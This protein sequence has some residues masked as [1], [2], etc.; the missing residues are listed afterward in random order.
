[1]NGMNNTDMAA[2]PI[3]VEFTLHD[4]ANPNVYSYEIVRCDR[5]SNDVRIVSQGVLSRPVIKKFL[6]KKVNKPQAYTP[7]GII[8]TNKLNIEPNVLNGGEDPGYRVDNLDNHNLYQYISPDVSY[9]RESSKLIIDKTNLHIN[10]VKYIFG[11]SAD[12]ASFNIISDSDR[13]D[14]NLYLS[15][16]T[17]F[18]GGIT[19]VKDGKGFVISNKISK[20]SYNSG[21]ISSMAFL[22]YDDPN[23]APTADYRANSYICNSISII[24]AI[25][26]TLGSNDDLSINVASGHLNDDGNFKVPNISGNVVNTESPVEAMKYNFNYF[27]L[28]CQS[29]YILVN[30]HDRNN[31][32]KAYEDGH[33]Y[34][35]IKRSVYNQ[36][37][38]TNYKFADSLK[39]DSLAT[40]KDGK[41]SE[42][43]SDKITNIDKYNFCNMVCWYGYNELFVAEN[44]DNIYFK[45]WS[46]YATGGSCMLI[47]IDNEW[48]NIIKD[49]F[50]NNYILSDTIGTD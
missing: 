28:Y 14:D 7:S 32:N 19:T 46:P 40:V 41:A 43:Y 10:P 3:G 22:G 6:D 23:L 38:I 39:W 31:P 15:H 8:S 36:C 9:L 21:V 25:H 13:R 17:M 16:S 37:N 12:R 49:K 34:V 44:K 24:N 2:L 29:N 27:K 26:N 50:Y 33:G 47:T 30:N 4:I 45:K 20:V 48:S 11:M 35:V 42:T 18:R 5:S 1:M